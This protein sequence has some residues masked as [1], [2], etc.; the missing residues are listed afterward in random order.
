M[1]TSPGTNSNWTRSRR[2]W[3]YLYKLAWTVGTYVL[4]VVMFTTVF[5]AVPLAARALTPYLSRHAGRDLAPYVIFA[6]CIVIVV[7]TAALVASLMAT[8]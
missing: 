7:V 3:L 8:Q 1:S 6:G 5:L 2:L 4:V